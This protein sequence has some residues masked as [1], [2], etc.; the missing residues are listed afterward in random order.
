MSYDLRNDNYEASYLKML[1][2]KYTK[3]FVDRSSEP[4][5]LSDNTRHELIFT[6]GSTVHY[7]PSFRNPD[8]EYEVLS[9]TPI[10]TTSPFGTLL[11]NVTIA[12][13]SNM[14]DVVTEMS[15]KLIRPDYVPL[16][17]IHQTREKGPYDKGGV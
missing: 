5:I 3:P 15:D 14:S 13:K 12:K 4:F 11:A 2:K 7:S 10:I 8:I 1:N 6:T 9:S 16:R 17:R